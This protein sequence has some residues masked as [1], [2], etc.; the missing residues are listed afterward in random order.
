MQLACYQQGHSFQRKTIEKVMAVEFWR[1]KLYFNLIPIWP[2]R[3]SVHK[4]CKKCSF[5]P[6]RHL[7]S[8]LYILSSCDRALNGDVFRLNKVSYS[9]HNFGA[10]LFFPPE[11][12][13]CVL[14]VGRHVGCSESKVLGC[15]LLGLDCSGLWIINGIEQTLSVIKVTL[16]YVFHL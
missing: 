3:S 11:G 2:W 13:L 12:L 5:Q 9:F 16:F 7:L 14:Y 10:Y 6:E 15:P 8:L 1:W 4:L